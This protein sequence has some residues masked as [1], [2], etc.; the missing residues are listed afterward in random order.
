[1]GRLDGVGSAAMAS[2]CIYNVVKS[3][4]MDKA[5]LLGG[6]QYHSLILK[7]AL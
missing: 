4:S 5:G 2:I 3:K 7:E 6:Y 1:M